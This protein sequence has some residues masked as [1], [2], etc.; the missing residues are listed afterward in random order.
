MACAKDGLMGRQAVGKAIESLH[1]RKS[2][3]FELCH[4]SGKRLLLSA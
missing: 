2:D 3:S 1:E 4:K